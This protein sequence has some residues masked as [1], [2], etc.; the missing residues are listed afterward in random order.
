MW[1]QIG[2]GRGPPHRGS[3]WK[4]DSARGRLPKVEHRAWKAIHTGHL[5]H[6]LSTKFCSTKAGSPRW[7]GLHVQNWHCTTVHIGSRSQVPNCMS[8]QQPECPTFSKATCPTNTQL[9]CIP[10]ELSRLSWWTASISRAG[11]VEKK[12]I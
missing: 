1:L 2:L 5:R 7:P 3:S 6:S 11:G 9:T 4:T 8:L 10:L 12:A